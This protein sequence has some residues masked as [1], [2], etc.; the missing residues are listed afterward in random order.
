MNIQVDDYVTT[1]H[2]RMLL[3]V[4][5]IHNTGHPHP[6]YATLLQVRQILAPYDLF[7]IRPN[8]IITHEKWW[9]IP[10]TIQ[11]KCP[12]AAEGEHECPDLN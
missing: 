4:V 12:E 1:A 5:S 2:H 3:R 9:H 10:G 6:D 8:S 7:D 11:C